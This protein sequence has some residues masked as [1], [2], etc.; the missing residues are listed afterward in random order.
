MN[1]PVKI[2]YLIKE[3]GAQSLLLY[4]G[5]KL[6]MKIGFFRWLKPPAVDTAALEDCEPADRFARTGIFP[7]EQNSF[8]QLFAKNLSNVLDQADEILA[9]SFRLFGGRLAKIDL[10]PPVTQHWSCLS[11]QPGGNSDIKDVWEPARFGWAYTLCRAYLLTGEEKYAEKF[12]QLTEEFIEYNPVNYGPNWA[13]AQEVA[14]R[15][16][17]LTFAAGCFRNSPSS[18]EQRLKLLLASI[19]AHAARIP[20]TLIYA[21]AQ[22]NNHLLVE[23]AGLLTAGVLFSDFSTGQKWLHLGWKWFNIAIQTQFSAAG[24]Y[25][26]QSVNYHRLALQASAWVFQLSKSLQKSFPQQSTQKLGQAVL[27]L[28]AQLDPISGKAPNLG[29]NDGAYLMPLGGEFADHRPIIQATSRLF[30]G[31]AV[32]PPGLWDELSYWLNIPLHDDHFSQSALSLVNPAVHK[33]GGPV[34]WATIRAEKFHGRP[35][36][37]DQLHVDLWWQGTNIALDPGTFRYT[38]PPPFNNSLARTGVHNTLEIEHQ[39]QMIR[40]GRFLWLRR[41][42]AEVIEKSPGNTPNRIV[43]RHNGYHAIRLIHQRELHWDGQTTWQIIDQI[44]PED[45]KQRICSFVITWMLPDS[46]WKLNEQRLVIQLPVGPASVT[47]APLAGKIIEMQPRLVRAGRCI[48]G[49]K[50][51]EPDLGWYSPTYGH[52]V[53]ALSFQV[54]CTANPPVKIS[55]TWILGAESSS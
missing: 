44:I 25:I 2:Y 26:Q 14:I 49:D 7:P 10:R 39:D 9:G 21:R 43:V 24:V 4:G 37:A 34:T 20:P 45:S 35:A 42:Q 51:V 13:S 41:A 8:R 47:I 17:A 40:A 48:A 6:G 15:I 12:W 50:E 3:L 11:D 29:H 23:A 1:L 19:Y 30:L 54:H 46:P 53:P 52:I 32:L 27:W 33:L 18:S 36:H 31:R 16:I 22:N 38:A 28:A 55:S 5:Y